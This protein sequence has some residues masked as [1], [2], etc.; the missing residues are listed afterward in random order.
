MLN[1]VFVT[2]TDKQGNVKWYN[3][4][5]EQGF[6]GYNASDILR[7]DSNSYIIAAS[8]SI[9]SD[10][11]H[12]LLVCI[13]SLGAVK[14]RFKGVPD[15]LESLVKSIAQLE[16]GNLLYCTRRLYSL[17]GSIKTISKL[18]CRDTAFNLV[19]EKEIS[20]TNWL[21]NS[22]LDMK[23]TPDGNFVLAAR[24]AP[25]PEFESP[26]WRAGCLYKFTP[27]GEELWM[28]CD[29]PY[30]GYPVPLTNQDLNVGGLAVLPSG[31]VVL[32]GSADRSIPSPQRIYGWMF[33]VDANGC[34]YA[35]CQVS[36][37]SP[38][39]KPQKLHVFP[40]PVRG[41]VTVRLPDLPQGGRLEVFDAFG[42]K[43]LEKTTDPSV[44]AAYLDTTV[45]PS[46][47]YFVQ[48]YA[49]GGR[50]VGVAKLVVL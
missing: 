2:A 9:S 28:V 32:A 50:L 47:T 24:W 8:E 35:P 19:W 33:K 26:E 45:W 46:G 1:R 49:S 42:R 11:G 3:E 41:P 5:W 17:N 27:E 23:P 15:Q 44:E 48:V 38:V 4:Y 40:I 43:V 21:F 12:S 18:V 16:N 34:Q 29:T 6:T 25:G 31:S 37:S 36:A 39:G 22:I 14:W 20:P 13:D 7:T 10:T 30:W